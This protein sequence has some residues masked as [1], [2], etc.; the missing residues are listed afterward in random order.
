M[1]VVIVGGNECM[2][3]QYKELCSE[4]GCKA[5][6]YP[7][8]NAGLK[9]LG[10]PDLIVLFTSTVSHK[11]VR[12]ALK[13]AETRIARSHSS[14]MNALRGILEEHACVPVRVR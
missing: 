10:N 6:I 5:K 1:S 13:G 7:K 4:Y 9:D 12:C 2:T 14:S 11:M 8:M 3:R